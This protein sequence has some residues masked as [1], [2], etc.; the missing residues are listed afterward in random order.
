MNRRAVVVLAMLAL[1]ATLPVGTVSAATGGRSV[2]KGSAPSWA[3]SRHY[4]GA[5]DPAAGVDFRVYLDWQNQ[6]GAESVARS[7]SDPR[8]A[9]YRHYLTAAQFRARF[10]PSAAQVG[11][12]KAWLKSQG[13][14][15]VYTPSN[16]KYIAAEGTVAQAAAAFGTSFGMYRINGQVLRSQRT[17]LSVPSSI[18]ASVA[19]VLGLDESGALVT[20]DHV[21]DQAAA[22]PTAGFRNSPPLST[23]WA[24]QVSPYAYPAGFT[25]RTNPATAPW[26]LKGYTPAQ[27][28]GA[29]G[30]SGSYDGAGQ[31]VAIIDPFASPT[32]LSDVNQWSLNRG[33]PTMTPGQLTQVVPPGAYNRAT[34]KRWNPSAAYSEE[35]LDVEAVHGMAP[36]AKIVYLGS[37]T[38]SQA[39]DALM[40][41]VVD[42]HL[43]QIVS[44]SYGFPTELLPPGYVKPFNDILIQAAAEGIGVYFASGDDGDNVSVT[45]R[46]SAG[47]P[48]SSPW[49]TSV[50]GTSLAIGSAGQYLWESGWGTTST[51][52]SHGRWS[53]AAP[54]PFLYGAGG[55]AS[56]VFDMPGYQAAQVPA[57]D[58]TWKGRLRRTEP[59][60]SMV[61]DPQT[62][63]TFS[64]TYVLP[65]GRQK[66]I[67]SWIGGT[68]L[69]APL[70]AGLMTLADQRTG[71][72][73]GFINPALYLMR[74]GGPLRDVTGG[75]QGI[76]VLR[77]ALVDGAVVTRLRSFD[78][79][80]SLAAAVG[81]DPV[82]GMG[83]PYGPAFIDALG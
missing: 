20:F 46:A 77:D 69:S 83:S 39:L 38:F 18:A 59:D 42:R 72:P 2:L 37:A 64:Q 23:Y 28:K 76:A 56:H 33:L 19:G 29:Y 52:W 40:N 14:T 48:D 61:A 71:A 7:V 17:N 79:D 82:T 3:D 60:L 51:D 65:S 58:A 50:G 35:T 80:S 8:S 15:I 24:Q 75:H 53:P 43:A 5:A 63:V 13:F 67:D 12:V 27:V 11:A 36:A 45:G 34:N 81:W 16:N 49:V 62:G 21:V 66:I 9:A 10:S 74:R 70:V 26:V 47:F 25:D 31:T 73:H 54:G 55:G 1:V 41:H 22:P 78:R 68:S 4:A 6:A 30:I 57:A 44:N 32:I